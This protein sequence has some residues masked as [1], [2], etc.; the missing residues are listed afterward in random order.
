MRALH[1]ATLIGGV[2]AVGGGGGAGQAAASPGAAEERAVVIEVP[3]IPGPYCAYGIE[4]RLR[5]APE[6]A[7]IET[8]WEAEEMRVYPTP[9]R[10][11]S[12]EIV[13]RAVEASEYP[14]EYTIRGR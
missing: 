13:R 9:Q 5:N 3:G 11:L 12:R 14:Y 8:D 2:V 6:V 1:A 10:L 7:R 4:K